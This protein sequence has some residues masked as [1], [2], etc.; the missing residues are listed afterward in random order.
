M[1]LKAEKKAFCKMDTFIHGVERKCYS[2]SKMIMLLK[3]QLVKWIKHHFVTA[4]GN[5]IK[6]KANQ[7]DHLLLCLSHLDN[8]IE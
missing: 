8:Y 7:I 5:R 1:C 4:I 6:P 3:L 2:S